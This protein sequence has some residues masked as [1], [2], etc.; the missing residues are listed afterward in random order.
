MLA[1][2]PL[3]AGERDER[4]LAMSGDGLVARLAI[5]KMKRVLLGCMREKII[6]A[7]LF[8]QARDERQMGLAILHAIFEFRESRF[9]QLA[10][11]LDAEIFQHVADNVRSL[12]P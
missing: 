2:A 12:L 6:D 3:V 11:A 7:V 8:H 5:G 1:I 4:H 9:V 10:L